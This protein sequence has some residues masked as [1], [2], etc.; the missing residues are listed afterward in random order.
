MSELLSTFALGPSW[1]RAAGGQQEHPPK[2]DFKSEDRPPRRGDDRGGDDRR[3]GSRDRDGGRDRDRDGGRR[4]FGDRGGERGGRFA[5]RGDDVP[6]YEE[7]PPA[8]GVR[9]TLIPDPQAVHLIGKEIHQVARVYALYDVAKILL[10]ERARCRA[11]FEAHAP[12]APLFRGKIDESVFLT[13][14]EALRHL[15]NS[16]LRNHFIEEETIEVDPPT[17]NFQS[18][19]RCGLSGEWLGP[20]NFHSYQVNLRRIHRERYPLMPFA[21]YQ[22]KVRTER[23][24]EA[25]NAWLET[26]RK[27]TRWHLK[28][29]ADDAWIED[30]AEAERTLTAKCF[31]Q[32]FDEARLIEVLA[33]IPPTHLSPSLLTSLKIAGNH[34]RN[35]PAILIPAVCRAVEAEHLPVFKRQGK[36]LTGPARP[37]PLPPGAVLAERPGIMVNWIRS[38]KPAKL[39]GLWKAVLPEGGTAP[40][41]EFAA[42]LF[43]LL[44]QGHI[45]LFTD[46]TLYVQDVRPPQAPDPASEKPNKKKSKKSKTPDKTSPDGIIPDEESPTEVLT[47]EALTDEAPT[48]EAPTDEAPA[49][50]TPADEAPADE[51]PADEAPAD[52]VPADGTPTDEVP[53]DETPADETPAD[54]VPADEVPADEVPA[55]E[56]PTDEVPADETPTDEI[57]ADEAPADEAPA[58]EAPVELPAIE[59]PVLTTPDPSAPLPEAPKHRNTEALAPAPSD[60]LSKNPSPRVDVPPGL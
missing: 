6:R 56:T 59:A 1:A 20:P 49:D 55:D 29:D 10:A 42:D 37:H 19:A 31:E 43:W 35:H 41:A 36:L 53:A 13:R 46:D 45:L 8:E 57:P 51:A 25:V 47:D 26:T 44:H 9:V 48:D 5:A 38:N 52:E 30:L 12:H 40:P 18:V 7:A 60:E 34:A 39:E 3:S 2:P 54:E 17:G 22:A 14:Q 27:K 28:G 33:S 16:D 24:E 11:V 50:E 23:G 58:D 21:A 4:S 32:A 15:W